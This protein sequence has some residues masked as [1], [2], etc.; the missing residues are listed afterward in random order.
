M[1]RAGYRRGGLIAGGARAEGT[2]WQYSTLQALLAGSYDGRLSVAEMARH[3]DLGLGTFDR[4]DGEMV[5]VDGRVWQVRVDGRP[6]EAAPATLVPFAAVIP[7]RPERQVALPAGLDLA[8][9]AA[10]LD[11]QVADRGQPQAIR[12]DGRFARLKLRSEA[13]QSPPY[14]PLAAVLKEQVVF[15]LADLDGTM[16]GFRFPAAL[17]AM[18]VPGWH[19]HFVSAD[20][21]HGGHVL[22][23]ATGPGAQAA[24]QTVT[25]LAAELPPGTAGLDD[26]PAAATVKQ[27]EGSGSK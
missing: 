21:R 16:V 10:F 15:E 24:L 26:K 13:A 8:G 19:F 4:V 11:G 12:I 25:G 9:L 6:V 17:A 18:N 27:I 14:R 1:G 22:D 7:F 5:V 3:G 20:R 2:V 23:L